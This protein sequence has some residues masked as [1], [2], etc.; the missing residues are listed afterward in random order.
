MATAIDAP[1]NGGAAVENG[2]FHPAILDFE[3]M[4]SRVEKSLVK[5]VRKLIEDFPDR[6]LEVIRG[7]MA[8]GA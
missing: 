7:W 8:E 1:A 6:A 3:Q 5:K 2:R 4:E